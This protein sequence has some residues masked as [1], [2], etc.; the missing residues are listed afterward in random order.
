[1]PRRHW[2]P[3][4][5]CAL[6][7]RTRNTPGSPQ[8]QRGA[9]KAALTRRARTRPVTLARTAASPPSDPPPRADRP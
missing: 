3:N 5:A 7:F 9:D 4:R 6:D 1:M 8:A 2:F